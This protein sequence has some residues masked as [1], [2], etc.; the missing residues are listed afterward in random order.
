V[1]GIPP[2]RKALS[3]PEAAPDPRTSLIEGRN[4]SRKRFLI[5]PI[6]CVASLGLASVLAARPVEKEGP[7]ANVARGRMVAASRCERCHAIEQ[8]DKSARP[9]APPF[10]VIAL[11]YGPDELQRE[12][13]TITEV[14]HFEMP[15]TLIEL[16][17]RRDLVAYIKSLH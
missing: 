9:T 6:V 17:E 4:V 16:A 1:V 2:Q 7:G 10:K 5:F 11:R 12:L 14:G 15:P 13:Q 8:S 3:A